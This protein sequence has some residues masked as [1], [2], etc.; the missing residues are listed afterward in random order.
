MNVDWEELAEQE[1]YS[2]FYVWKF[3]ITKL[4]GLVAGVLSVNTLVDINGYAS[5]MPYID[6]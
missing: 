3:Y 2:T 6:K 5:N 4:V 1:W